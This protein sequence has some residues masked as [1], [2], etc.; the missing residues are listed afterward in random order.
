M[1]YFLPVIS[2]LVFADIIRLIFVGE[3]GLV[4]AICISLFVGY[5]NGFIAGHHEGLTTK[6]PEGEIHE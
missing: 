3:V 1:R 4:A 6:I 2:I 5:Q